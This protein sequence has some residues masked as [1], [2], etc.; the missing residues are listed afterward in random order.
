MGYPTDKAATAALTQVDDL[1]RLAGGDP[2]LKQRL[3]D[4]IWERSKRGGQLPAVHEVRR[5]LG[6]RRDPAAGEAFAEAWDAWLRGRRRARP[7]YARSLD[8]IGRLWLLPVLADVE[9]DRLGGEHC[10]LVFERIGSFNAEIE[11]ARAEG[12]EPVL[13]GDSRA[14]PKVVGMATQHRILAALRVFLNLAWKVRHVI[15]FNPVYAVELEPEVTG[16]AAVVRC[17]GQL[18]PGRVRGRSSR[19][20]VPHCRAPRRAACRSSQLPVVRRRPGRRLSVR[21]APHPAARRNY[22]RGPA[23]D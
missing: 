8:Q 9:L 20:D 19:P 7:S 23:E 4:L 13:A 11:A 6:L 21:R 14:R 5:R 15:P 22:G 2:F 17:P 10:V 1:I 18:V 16:G 12:R 3:G